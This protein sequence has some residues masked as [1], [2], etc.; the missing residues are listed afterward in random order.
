MQ[1]KR[2]AMTE[3]KLEDEATGRDEESLMADQAP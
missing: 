2:K 3:K 1:R